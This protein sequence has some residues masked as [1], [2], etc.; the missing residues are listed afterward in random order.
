M[1]SQIIK[2]LIHSFIHLK[3]MACHI[4]FALWHCSLPQLLALKWF[5]FQKQ[6]PVLDHLTHLIWVPHGFIVY[7]EL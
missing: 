4:Y 6:R 7:P 1:T 5:L 3:S 2:V